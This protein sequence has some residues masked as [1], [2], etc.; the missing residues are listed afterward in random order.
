[1]R[2]LVCPFKRKQAYYFQKKKQKTKI[3]L[4]WF[5]EYNS[6]SS[7]MH[8]HY[9]SLEVNRLNLNIHNHKSCTYWTVPSG[10]SIWTQ[11]PA[12]TTGWLT[13]TWGT[14]PFVF[15][16]DTDS[17]TTVVTQLVQV[18]KRET[19]NLR[20]NGWGGRSFSSWLLQLVYLLKQLFKHSTSR[21]GIR[22]SV[23]MSWCLTCFVV[24][25]LPFWFFVLSLSPIANLKVDFML[26]TSLLKDFTV[27]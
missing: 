15:L 22:N 4:H 12:C 3:R 5:I 25:A 23:A 9:F 6:R 21:G 11:F 20:L 27:W 1:M 16:E 19:C 7:E 17:G 10:N 14:V 18:G 13:W 2:M 24:G 26:C 8:M